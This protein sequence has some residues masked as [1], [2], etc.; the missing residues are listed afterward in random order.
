[1]FCHLPVYSEVEEVVV[2]EIGQGGVGGVLVGNGAGN[3]AEGEL[4]IEQGT[5]AGEEPGV[6]LIELILG[7][8]HAMFIGFAELGDNHA[9]E[10]A[11]QPLAAGELVSMAPYTDEVRAVS[12]E[13]IGVVVA[14]DE[15]VKAGAVLIQP[16]IE[17][18][19]APMP[20][21]HDTL[22]RVGMIQSVADFHAAGPDSQM[23][24]ICTL[25]ELCKHAGCVVLWMDD[26]HGRYGFLYILYM[27]FCHDFSVGSAGFYRY[28]SVSDLLMPK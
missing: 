3:V 27:A 8:G 4:C 21:E 24:E 15:P 10:K 20:Q 23:L 17:T 13:G 11:V 6:F 19:R 9:G 18:R 14:D 5:Q 12:A 7:G 26:E 16:G 2:V 22:L 28:G 25:I 1:M